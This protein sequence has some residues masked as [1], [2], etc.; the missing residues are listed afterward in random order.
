MSTIF[1]NNFNV[2]DWI[3]QSEAARIRNVSR[4][5]IHKLVKSGRLRTVVI[6]GIIFVNRKEIELFNS[7]K[8]GRPKKE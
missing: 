7:K 6:G 3:S 5:A 8:T 2:E 4:Q 1:E